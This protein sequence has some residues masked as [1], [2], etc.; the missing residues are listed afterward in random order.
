MS[1]MRRAIAVGLGVALAIGCLEVG[2]RQVFWLVSDLDPVF[3]PIRRPGSVA[4]WW[5]EGHGASH[6]TEHGVRATA[7]PANGSRPLLAVGDSFTEA[8]NVDDEFVFTE[9]LEAL[10]GASGAA[11]PIVNVGR[12]G[13]SPADY[14]AFAP[15]YLELFAPR[16][17]IVQLRAP[18][19]EAEGFDAS[20]THFRR[21]S[22]GALD[23]VVV[24]PP[25]SRVHHLLLPLRSHSAL[26]NYAI[27]RALEYVAATTREP[28]LF[29][30]GSQVSSGPP[31]RPSRSL[32]CLRPSRKPTRIA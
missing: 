21:D 10:L 24:P 30:A 31:A 7:L 22:S 13:A 32:R 4:R 18:D 27:V 5:R 3:G 28:P 1:R 15:R 19:L 11:I 9:R 25:P 6:W 16:W 29:R 8:L 23:A 17:T 12:S 2:M 20:E 14:V 26:V